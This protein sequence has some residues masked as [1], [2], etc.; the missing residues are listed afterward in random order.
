[1]SEYNRMLD[2]YWIGRAALGDPLAFE[3][4][5]DGEHFTLTQCGD[6][7][8][9]RNHEHLWFHIRSQRDEWGRLEKLRELMHK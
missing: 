1:M 8:V 4:L 2:P 5:T 7:G 9:N 6:L 3:E